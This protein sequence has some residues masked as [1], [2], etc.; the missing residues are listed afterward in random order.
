MPGTVSSEKNIRFI[1][2]LLVAKEK[3]VKKKKSL[4]ILVVQAFIKAVKTNSDYISNIS[5]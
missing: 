5:K 2:I 4:N 3:R 1:P